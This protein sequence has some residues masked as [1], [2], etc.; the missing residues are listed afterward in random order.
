MDNLNKLI[1][2]TFGI[3]K[4][5]LHDSLTSDDIEK[6]DS[7]GQFFL[8]S[9]LEKTYDIVL[10]IDEIFSMVTIGDIRK[11]VETKIND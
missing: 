7:L 5:D 4:V 1:C 10:E 9:R 11:I 6:W 3:D 8:I 2:D